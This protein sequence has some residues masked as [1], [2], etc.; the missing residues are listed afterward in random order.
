MNDLSYLQYTNVIIDNFVNKVLEDGGTVDEVL[1]RNEYNNLHT[2]NKKQSTLTMIGGAYKATKLYGMN[3]QTSALIPFTFS[4]TGVATRVNRD[5]L[6]E[7]VPAD[8][9]RMDYDPVTKKFKGLLMEK[10]G[11]NLLAR[12][13]EFDNA[14]WAKS[15]SSVTAN[16]ISAP[17]G[18]N[19]ADKLVE[20]T[21]SGQEHFISQA[22]DSV[23]TPETVTFSVYAK[24]GERTWIGLQLS[25][26]INSSVHVYFDLIAGVKG[27]L[28]TGADYSGASAEIIPAGNGWYRCSLAATKGNTVNT[29][30]RPTIHI[31]TGNNSAQ[32]TG[33]G[34]S[35]IYI[36]GAQLETSTYPTSYIPT[37]GTSVSRGNEFCNMAIGS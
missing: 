29:I 1:L 27:S 15:N 19:T 26:N 17:D 4:R 8:T 25:N 22:R 37:A 32:Y 24:A 28:I 23:T 2:I 12:S 5:G 31:R 6:L 13:E 21:A 14:V 10:G 7:T 36:W 18:S 30:N 16:T 9:P 35:G 33:D 20:N 3:P 11:A 34:V